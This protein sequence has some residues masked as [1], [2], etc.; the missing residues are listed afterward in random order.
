MNS[1]NPYTFVTFSMELRLKQNGNPVISLGT[2]THTTAWSNFVIGIPAGYSG[3]NFSVEFHLLNYANAA[4]L[5]F[6]LDEISV[7][8]GLAT[9]ISSSTP[10][11]I[12]CSLFQD[13]ANRGLLSYQ[14]SNEVQTV[15]VLSA[16]GKIVCAQVAGPDN[17]LDLSN[18]PG[19]I[20][21]IKFLCAE[22]IIVKK[23]II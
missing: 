2:F 14:L 20:Y 8:A 11:G 9:S 18:Y 22:G 23:I 17:K 7:A 1:Y 3:S 5:R 6:Y 13:A 21:V 10:D 16:D 12:E 19:G 4:N 15:Q